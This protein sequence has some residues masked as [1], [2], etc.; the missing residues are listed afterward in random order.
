MARYNI[1]TDGSAR[2]NP[3]AGGWG[4]VVLN[5]EENSI[6][7]MEHDTE[8]YT[9]NNRM[10]LKALI[11]A[12]NYAES[13]PQDQFIIYSDSAYAVN[14]CRDWIFSWARNGWV[15]S[16]KKTVENLELM[17][18][19]YAHLKRPYPNFRIEKCP[20]HAGLVG[21]ELADALATGSRTKFKELAEYYFNIE[22]ADFD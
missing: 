16:K 2:F 13:H 18:G 10:E 9:T 22:I 20:G 7:F 6:V 19:I 17:Q 14:A 21:N 5:E 12:L 1:Y 15:N 3:G 11:C 4:A 8:E